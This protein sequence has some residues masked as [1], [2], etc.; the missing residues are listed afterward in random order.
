MARSMGGREGGVREKEREMH[1]IRSCEACLV[2]CYTLNFDFIFKA[3][4]N[5]EAF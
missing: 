2:L 3:A 4:E 5:H 1:A